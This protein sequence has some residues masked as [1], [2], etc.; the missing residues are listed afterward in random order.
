MPNTAHYCLF[1]LSATCTLLCSP[2]VVHGPSPALFVTPP[3]TPL[4]P[5]QF[6]SHAFSRS[7]SLITRPSASTAV[8]T[9]RY[10]PSSSALSHCHTCIAYYERHHNPPPRHPQADSVI[11]IVPPSSF[12]S[13]PTCHPRAS[14]SILVSHLRSSTPSPSPATTHRCHIP[15]FCHV[16]ANAIML[17]PSNYGMLH[18]HFY[19][20]W[21]NASS[22]SHSPPCLLSHSHSPPCPCCAAHHRERPHA[23]DWPPNQ[24]LSVCITATF[25]ESPAPIATR[26][27]AS[28]PAL[29]RTHP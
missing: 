26:H 20:H 21:S 28:R 29:S 8:S 11:V 18:R 14:S 9:R 13:F 5:A 16:A 22:R 2:H 6:A 23:P 17:I 15:S 10:T 1:L 3:T 27:V 7:C 4:D 24:S 12:S 25:V 19:V